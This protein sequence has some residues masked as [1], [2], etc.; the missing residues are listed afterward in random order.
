MLHGVSDI[1][2]LN[3]VLDHNGS[4]EVRRVLVVVTAKGLLPTI[5]PQR[6]ELLVKTEKEELSVI[7]HLRIE[8]TI[9]GRKKEYLHVSSHDAVDDELS[10]TAK[11]FFVGA[12]AA[13]ELRIG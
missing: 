10:E 5:V 1:G 3:N 7:L 12:D 13:Q 9:F 8:E 11:L 4:L 2:S 6:Q